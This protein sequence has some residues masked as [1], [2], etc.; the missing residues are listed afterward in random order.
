[1]RLPLWR[2]SIGSKIKHLPYQWD[3]KGNGSSQWCSYRRTV[4]VAGSLAPSEPFQSRGIERVMQL[5][6]AAQGEE[7]DRGN[8]LEGCHQV[9]HPWT[10]PV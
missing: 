6:W 5:V 8:T 3:S 4:T 10:S 9:H 2:L 1:M 7:L